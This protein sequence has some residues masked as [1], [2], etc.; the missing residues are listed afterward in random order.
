[1]PKQ[2]RIIVIAPN[3]PTN[4]YWSELRVN[5]SPRNRRERLGD[6]LRRIAA[7]IDGRHS[8]SV[9]INTLPVIDADTKLACIRAGVKA[10]GKAVDSETHAAM[11]NA[12]IQ[13]H[14][15]SLYADMCGEK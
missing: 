14:M 4:I 7:R 5:A 9:E 3:I 10:M 15:P 1:M 2:S 8:L 13:M 6:W 12:Q 11:L